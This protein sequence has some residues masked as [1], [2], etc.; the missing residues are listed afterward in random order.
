MPTWWRFGQDGKPD[1]EA[2]KWTHV[3]PGDVVQSRGTVAYR[4]RDWENRNDE[5]THV[6]QLHSAPMLVL[7]RIPGI[8][9]PDGEGPE[10]GHVTFV[11]LSR[12]GLLILVQ[13]P[14]LGA[15]DEPGPP[16]RLQ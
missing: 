12:H 2:W 15:P 9:G 11:V 3:M 6:V 1:M 7:S 5:K 14:H 16:V 10:S 13:S 8:P 4:H